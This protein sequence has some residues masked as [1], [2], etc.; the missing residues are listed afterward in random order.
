MFIKILTLT[1]KWSMYC[2]FNGTHL[3]NLTIKLRVKFCIYYEQRRTLT[4]A[5]AI[6]NDLIVII[7]SQIHVLY[8]H[9]PLLSRSWSNIHNMHCT[10]FTRKQRKFN[11]NVHVFR[12]AAKKS[13]L[14]VSTNFFHVDH[15]NIILWKT[16][17]CWWQ[18]LNQY[19]LYP[20]DN[21]T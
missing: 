17:Y 9:G 13:M 14:P 15:S 19:I 12:F 7:I 2:S 20:N 3:Y 21:F 1:C 10:Y 18:A 8:F 5:H 16:F 4:F 6:N 11:Y